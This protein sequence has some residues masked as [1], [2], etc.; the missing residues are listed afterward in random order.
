[1][2]CRQKK[3]KLKQVKKDILNVLTRSTGLT[4]CAHMQSQKYVLC[5]AFT[6]FYFKGLS[7]S[8]KIP[9]I[10]DLFLCKYMCAQNLR[11]PNL[12]RS[13]LKIIYLQHEKQLC[14]ITFDCC[15]ANVVQSFDLL[16]VTWPFW[17]MTTW[18][19]FLNCRQ[20]TLCSNTL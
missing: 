11:T 14:I 3:T 4:H 20:N 15:S 5:K 19:N 9:W 7:K 13:E 12:Y 1:M 10:C 8:F 6:S 16:F 17:V 18:I 2:K